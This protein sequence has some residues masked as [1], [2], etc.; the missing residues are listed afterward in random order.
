MRVGQDG[1][2][3]A[4]KLLHGLKTDGCVVRGALGVMPVWRGHIARAGAL[5][6]QACGLGWGL[7][8]SL[9][10][11]PAQEWSFSASTYPSCFRAIKSIGTEQ[12]SNV[13]NSL[14]RQRLGGGRPVLA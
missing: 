3:A 11:P 1:H 9:T 8:Q 2:R 14:F 6:R 12:A 4:E 13:Y 7:G 5:W 10:P